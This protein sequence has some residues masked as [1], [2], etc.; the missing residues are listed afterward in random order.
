MAGDT[1]TAATVMKMAEGLDTGPTAME[2]RVRIGPDMTAGE[3]HDVLA[4]R[5][6]DLMVHAL[7]ALAHGTL[8]LAPQPEAGVTYAAKIDRNETRIDWTRPWKAVHDHCRGLSPFPGAW[9]ELP[10]AGAALRIKVLHTTRGD[11]SGA[12]G[13][14]IDDRLT[15]ACGDGAVRILE[16]QRAGGQPMTAEAFLRGVPLAAGTRLA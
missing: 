16:L 8:A 2:D 10:R 3:L 13:T 11:G 4:Q 5:G 15:I 12:P 9:F 7:D 14:A 1:E 6:A